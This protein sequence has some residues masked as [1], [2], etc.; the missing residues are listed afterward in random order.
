MRECQ[1]NFI[2]WGELRGDG[3]DLG[4]KASND[5][6]KIK[7]LDIITSNGVCKWDKMYKVIGRQM[8]S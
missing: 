7:T 2:Q 1:D 3:I 6:Q 4:S 5:E 8:L